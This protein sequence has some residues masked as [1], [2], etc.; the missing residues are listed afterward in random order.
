MVQGAACG[1][2]DIGVVVVSHDSA[3][4]LPSCLA[5]LCDADGIR[6]IVVVDNASQDGSQE[7]VRGIGD[8]RV[9]LLEPGYNSGFAGGCNHGFA[10]LPSEL[11]TVVFMN[12]DVVVSRDC[13]VRCAARLAADDTLAGVAPRLVRAD[14]E[15]IDSVGQVLRPWRLEVRDRGYGEPLAPSLLEERLVL[16]ACGAL[17]VFRRRALL[18]VNEPSGPWAAHY[19]CFWEDLELGWRLNNQGWRISTLPSAV[20][21]HRRGAGAQPGSGPLRWRRPVHLEACILVNRWLTLIRHL[22]P[23]DLVA[24]LP[25][26]LVWDLLAVILGVARRPALAAQLLR[27]RA[28]LLQ[29]WRRRRDRPRRRLRELPCC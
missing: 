21:G 20:A 2:G 24:R 13:L 23:L 18:T 15:T 16:A 17:A 7:V 6:T 22:H 9:R 26:L 3:E 4:D 12:P 14:G 28:L 27:R 10:A 29:E 11:G 19:F 8:P 1:D 25:L 5:A